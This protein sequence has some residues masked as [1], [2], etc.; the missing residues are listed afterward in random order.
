MSCILFL[1]DH[2]VSIPP[3]PDMAAKQPFNVTAV[4]SGELVFE[5]RCGKIRFGFRIGSDKEV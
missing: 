3:L 2:K 5:L 4:S 1:V